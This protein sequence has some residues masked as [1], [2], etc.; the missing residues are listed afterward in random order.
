MVRKIDGSD[1]KTFRVDNNVVDIAMNPQNYVEA[2]QIESGGNKNDMKI[3]GQFSVEPLFAN[4]YML[5][6]CQHQGISGGT[7]QIL[8]YYD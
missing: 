4:Q 7:A 8:K 6:Y 3:A 2:D 5:P 1:W